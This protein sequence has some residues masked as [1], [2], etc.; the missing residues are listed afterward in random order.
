MRLKA[1][2]RDTI[3]SGC[4]SGGIGRRARLKIVWPPGHVGSTPTFGTIFIL[5]FRSV[6]WYLSQVVLRLLALREATTHAE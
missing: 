5:T 3:F 4:R 2:E 6:L 1:T